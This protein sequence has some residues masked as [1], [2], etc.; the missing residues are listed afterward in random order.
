VGHDRGFA[1][2]AEAHESENTRAAGTPKGVQL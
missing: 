2:T 1:R